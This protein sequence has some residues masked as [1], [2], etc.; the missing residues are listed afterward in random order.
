MDEFDDELGGDRN[1]AI[2]E[3][4]QHVENLHRIKKDFDAMMST[5]TVCASN[6]S[7]IVPVSATISLAD[8]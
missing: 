4:E 5:A 8:S 3:I 2:I 6:V 1:T 7:F